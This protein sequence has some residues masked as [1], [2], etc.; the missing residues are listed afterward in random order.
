MMY[1]IKRYI[2]IILPVIIVIVGLIYF[3]MNHSLAKELESEKVVEEYAPLEE[4]IAQ[5]DQVQEEMTTEKIVVDIKGEINTPGVYEMD[6]GDRM[7][8]II[9]RSGGLTEE[10]DESQINLAQ[11]LLDEMVIIVPKE[12]EEMMELDSFSMDSS[13]SAQS[14]EKVNLNQATQ[15][16]LETLNGIGPS[17]AEAIIT[18]REENGLFQSVDEI[19]EV[20]GIGEKLLESI[21]ERVVV[22]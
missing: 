5:E 16:E 19:I 3:Y 17:K 8:D 4:N 6:I 15:S 22:H 20:S 18:Y 7:V 2:K 9:G 10:A 13:T 1:E 21:E 14:I 12:G 11:K